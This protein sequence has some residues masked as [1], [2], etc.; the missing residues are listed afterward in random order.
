MGMRKC[1]FVVLAALLFLTC[2]NRETPD[3]PV[4]VL[5]VGLAETRTSLGPSADGRRKV[6]WSEGD[7]ISVNG[8]VSD[9]LSG[10]PEGSSQ[11]DFRFTSALSTPYNIVYPASIRN[12]AYT[13]I[14]PAEQ[15]FVDGGI[16][17]CTLP[18]AGYSADGSSASI[19]HLCALVCVSVKRGSAAATI[20]SLSFS[21]NAMEQVSGEFEIDYRSHTL[22]PT[23]YDE[24]DW[25]VTVNVGA[26]LPASAPLE[27]CVA[28]PAATY[29]A[30]FTI[31]LKGSG[32][33]M[34][35]EVSRSVTLEAGHIYVLDAFA[36]EPTEPEE[37]NVTGRV[38]DN[39]GKPVEG[40]VVTDGAQ[41]TKTLA[42]GK[43]YMTSDL[44]SVKFV[45]ISTPS[46]YLPRVENGIPKFYKPVS[47]SSGTFNC[48]DFVLTPVPDP[49]NC[50]IFFMA[51]PQPRKS[52]YGYDKIGYHS[53]NCC[54]D[55]YRELKETASATGGQVYGVCLGDI[56]H[57]DM[58]LYTQYT[59]GLKTLGYPT[60]NVI[61]NHDH[62]PSAADDAAGAANY[63]SY[64][65]P[66]NYSFNIGKMHFVVLDNILM[67]K[68][69]GALKSYNVG[70]TDQAWQWLQADLAMVPTST[71]LNVCSHAP[72][73][74]T[75]GGGEISGRSTTPHGNDY[76]LLLRGYT[77][78]H[79]W[80]G[81]THRTFNYVYPSSHRHRRINVH[82]LARCTGELWTN[83][84]LA[85]GTPR[86]FT[87]VE[88]RG[89][90]IASWRFH[91][92]KYQS[93][94]FA[95][96]T[97]QPEY[98]W[99][100]WTYN[101]SGVAQMKGGGDLYESYQMHLYPPGSYAV[102]DGYL[103]A[104]VFLYD[105]SWGTPTFTLD[106]GSATSMTLVEETS[107]H[108]LATTEFKTFYKNNNPTMNGDN[109][110]EASITGNL[111]TLFRVQA[112]ATGS[113]TVSVRDRFGN[114]Y[115]RTISW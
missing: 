100:D 69:S 44:P 17:S 74:R 108:D 95:G 18:M 76:S 3:E 103:Y 16:A 39:A 32:G 50:T 75:D 25:Q 56:V 61:G 86:G 60:F 77:E 106:G 102:S 46:G 83:E 26:P 49:D 68:E 23:S 71:V 45:Y 55:L 110:Y 10:V 5:R 52:S 37:Y 51:D 96:T 28:V 57:E 94:A 6:Y 48:G 22:I 62:N 84:Y 92:T 14:L 66:A 1:F 93:S 104:N 109:S 99:R 63:E 31:K 89:G 24:A 87:I 101:S 82:T 58:S 115:T 34:T 13:V 29:D 91:P 53:L 54:S 8:V 43:F 67:Y 78:V 47:A 2:C 88:V 79:A 4:T 19:G 73:F 85:A 36:F 38:V 33:A 114:V 40:V 11:A 107:C 7:C 105:T 112:P 12:D 65:G 41:C 15:A 90:R 98:K 111:H 70:L 30:G 35:K 21:S 64:F 20:S 113:G 59:S 27:M 80:A 42:D 72:M 97:G 81:H 9:P